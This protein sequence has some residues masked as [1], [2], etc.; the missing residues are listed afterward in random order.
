MAITSRSGNTPNRSAAKALPSRPK[1]LMTFVEDQQDAVPGADLAQALQIAHGRRQHPG[2]AGERFDDHRGDGGG[3]VQR[4]QPLER[5]GAGNAALRL[6]ARKGVG[7]VMGVRQVVDAGEQA[8]VEL[9][10][11]RNPAHRDAAKADPMIAALAPDQTGATSLPGDAVIGE[12]DLERGIH[13]LGPGIGEKDAIEV[14]GQHGSQARRQGEAERMTE[15]EGWRIVE[16][17]RL[18]RERLGDTRAAMAGI[19]A[20]QP[21]GRVQ[22]LTAVAAGVVHA[23]RRDQHARRRLEGAVVGERHPPGVEVVGY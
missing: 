5:V 19:D 4:H 21:G 3:V 16:L 11:C 22:H 13:C 18:C 9:A 1:P 10:V 2:R 20:P 7:R 15:L 12:G 23:A 17:H 14:A 8:A 6:A